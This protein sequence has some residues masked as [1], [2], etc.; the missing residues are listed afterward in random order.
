MTAVVRA[1]NCMLALRADYVVALV[2][3]H[4]HFASAYAGHPWIKTEVDE[5][6]PLRVD[7]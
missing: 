6:R 7:G 5:T 3:P 4:F 1:V 2:I